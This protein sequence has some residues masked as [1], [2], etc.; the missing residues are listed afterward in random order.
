[1]RGA[2]ALELVRR[3]FARVDQITLD[4]TIIESAASLAP[5]V[6]ERTLDAVH[7]ATTL[8][9]GSELRGIV[10]YDVPMAL[11]ARSIGFTAET[12]T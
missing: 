9:V 4:E 12:P 2:D 11:A 1:V 10:T 8:I 5:R 7:L 6:Q 3:H